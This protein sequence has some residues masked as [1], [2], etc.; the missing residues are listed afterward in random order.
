MEYV[1][2][3]PL[4]M[5]TVKN[6]YNSNLYYSNIEDLN[7]AGECLFEIEDDIQENKSSIDKFIKEVDEIVLRYDLDMSDMF[8]RYSSRLRNTGSNA[9]EVAVYIVAGI[10]KKYKIGSFSG[11]KGSNNPIMWGHYG[12]KS[13]GVCLSYEISEGKD[14]NYIEDRDIIPLKVSEIR[15]NNIESICKKVF[16]NKHIN[17]RYEDEHRVL[18]CKNINSID[19]SCLKSV[20]FGECVNIDDAVL[21]IDIVKKLYSD[22]S[23]GVAHH[24]RVDSTMVLSFREDKNDL[25]RVL[26]DL[27]RQ[28]VFGD[29][30]LM[31]SFLKEAMNEKRRN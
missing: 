27:Q 25:I 31:E 3:C 11:G 18:S 21:L 13:T 29:R 22:V 5:W 30:Y 9:K 23:F 16:Y 1:K 10:L 6:I 4:N 20:V 19:R 2:F 24:R 7:D 8:Q 28:D 17:W 14:V 26:Q 15:L 12:N